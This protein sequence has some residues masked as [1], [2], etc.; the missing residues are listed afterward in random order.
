MT[1]EAQQAAIA[2]SL[3]WKTE[4]RG[5]GVLIRWHSDDWINPQGEWDD[6]PDYL[7]DIKAMHEAEKTLPNHPFYIRY[8]GEV[9]N[10]CLDESADY[11]DWWLMCH[12]TAAQRAEA[13]LRT[14]GKWVD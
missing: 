2:K 14:I 10:A 8:L 9:V 1:P 11:E 7:N 4:R 13:F 6:P 5:H 12:A 3:G